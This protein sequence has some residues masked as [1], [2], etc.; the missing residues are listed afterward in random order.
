MSRVSKHNRLKVLFLPAWYPSEIHPIAGIFIKEHAKAASVYNDIVVLYAYPDPYPQRRHLC[1]A[2][3]DIEDGIRTIRVKYSGGIPLYLWRKIT[4]KKQKPE[5]LSDSGTKAT[6]LGKFFAVPRM[7]IGDLL[8]CWSIFSAFRKL[9]KEGW[10]PDVI[11]AHVFTAGVP[12]AILGRLYRI[13][14]VVTEHYTGF[15]RHILTLSQRIKARF[16]MNR[17]QIVLPVSNALK[18]AIETY[19]IKNKF[20]IVPN[21]VNTEIFRPLSS[22]DSRGRNEGKKLLLVAILSPQKGI[23][24]LLEALSQIRHKRRDFSLDVVGD[25][26]NRGEYEKLTKHLG[27]GDVV[28]F[29][30]FKPKEEAAEFMRNCDFFVQ[31]SL[32]E[33]FGVVYIEAMACGKPVIASEVTGPQEII[34]KSVGILVPPKDVNALKEAIEYMLDNCQNYSPEKISQYAKERFGYE[35]V[36]RR[37]DVIYHEIV[38]RVI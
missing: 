12:A 11:H 19:G 33:T 31:P 25:G 17:A 2:F 13:P 5:G 18:E 7:I 6:I 20:Q 29:H 30:G 15:P 32:W 1:R 27:L 8:Y 38:R 21:V 4:A 36:G 26:P 14:F 3:Q 10:K 28:K 22:R 9:L 37:L 34:D 16:V 24:C 23:P 35:A